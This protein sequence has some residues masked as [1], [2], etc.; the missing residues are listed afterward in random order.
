MRSS[1]TLKR[2]RDQTSEEFRW[3][4]LLAI[5]PWVFFG[6]AIVLFGLLAVLSYQGKT[7]SSFIVL[8]GAVF[9]AT[10]VYIDHVSEIAATATA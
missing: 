8:L 6:I 1:T 2:S 9:S 5:E 3:T 10:F 7:V 4:R